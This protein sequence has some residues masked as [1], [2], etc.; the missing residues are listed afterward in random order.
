MR[1][2]PPVRNQLRIRCLHVLWRQDFIL[3]GKCKLKTRT[4]MGWENLHPPLFVATRFH[5]VGEVQVENSHPHGKTRSPRLLWRQDFHHVSCGD[6]ISSCRGSA[7]WKLAPTW[8]NVQLT[9][10]VATRFHLVEGMCKLENSHPHGKTC[11]PPLFVATRFHR[12]GHVQVENLHPHGKTCTPPLLWRQDSIL[13]GKQV[14]NVHPQK[15]WNAAL[16]GPILPR[17]ARHTAAGQCTAARFG[18]GTKA[19]TIPES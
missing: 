6:E 16:F 5:L 13:S 9:S 15:A 4:H 2:L 14:E 7:S 8:E 12:V 17:H 10:L 11:T 3:S 19:D 1:S 18:D